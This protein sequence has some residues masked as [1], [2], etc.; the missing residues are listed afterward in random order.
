VK[1][2]FGYYVFKVNKNTPGSQQSLDQAKAS[3]KQILS[4]QNQQKALQAFVKK[5][6]KKWK[7]R[8]DCRKGYVVQT[9]NNAPKQ[10]TTQTV[11]PG[12][13]PQQ[14]GGAQQVPQQGGAQQVPQQGG[15]QQVPAQP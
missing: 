6:Q 14:Q 1:T 2:Q 7:S 5:F 3:I 15:A 8:T 9:C 10:N 13:V 4:S 12:A 11:A